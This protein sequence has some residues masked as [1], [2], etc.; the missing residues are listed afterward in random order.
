M[1]ICKGFFKSE[2]KEKDIVEVSKIDCIMDMADYSI[3]RALS[4]VSFQK[5]SCFIKVMAQIKMG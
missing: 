4:R 3:I 2:Q 5:E 1:D